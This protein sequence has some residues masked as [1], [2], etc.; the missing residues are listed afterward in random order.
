[1]VAPY[2]LPGKD[3]C[4]RSRYRSLCSWLSCRDVVPAQAL[5][6]SHTPWG[7][8][9]QPF[10]FITLSAVHPQARYQQVP[11][12]ALTATATELVKQDIMRK[13]AID[14]TATVFKVWPCCRC[15]EPCIVILS[16]HTCSVARRSI[17][18][19]EEICVI[20]LQR[21]LVTL[22]ASGKH[23]LRHRPAFTGRT[24]TLSCTTNRRVVQRITSQPTW[25]C[26]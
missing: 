12:M 19:R 25:R 13:L 20:I 21:T 9:P 24:L 22:S 26:C 5:A 16:K 3:K 1:M 18:T 10:N 23:T 15:P 6:N 14:R 8:C 7:P 11:I 2:K 4:C 17:C